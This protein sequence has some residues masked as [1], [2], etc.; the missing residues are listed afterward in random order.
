MK[1]APPGWQPH[2][3][4]SRVDGWVVDPQNKSGIPARV[5]E[6]IARAMPQPADPRVAAIRARMV[7]RQLKVLGY[8]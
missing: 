3:I 4:I 7:A 8:V 1:S 5:A 2:K 6:M